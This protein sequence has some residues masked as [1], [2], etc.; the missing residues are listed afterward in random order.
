MV[1]IGRCKVVAVAVAGGLAALLERFGG[2]SNSSQ[3]TRGLGPQM[4][5]RSVEGVVTG[6]GARTMQVSETGQGL[7]EYNISLAAIGAK[8][9]RND[10]D[11]W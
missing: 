7:R 1:N 5:K 8:K 6:S 4:G 3:L 11:R 10:S 2:C 9:R